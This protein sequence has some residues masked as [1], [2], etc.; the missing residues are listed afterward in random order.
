M[1]KDKSG[2]WSALSELVVRKKKPD[3]QVLSD[4]LP[5][6]EWP[7]LPVVSEKI[8][9]LITGGKPDLYQNPLLYALRRWGNKLP[10]A[11]LKLLFMGKTRQLP[12]F[13]SIPEISEIVVV[14]PEDMEEIEKAAS[15]DKRISIYQTDWKAP[16][17]PAGLF[18]L[19]FFWDYLANQVN[20]EK[21]F[22][23]LGQKLAIGGLVILKEYVGPERYQFTG[24]QLGVANALLALF[25]EN[26]RRDI[27]GILLKEQIPPDLG[28]L[29]ANYPSLAV[30]SSDIIGLVRKNFNIHEEEELGGTVISPLL[31]GIM[32]CFINADAKSRRLLETVW[33]LER[34]LL[35]N[36]LLEND[37]WFASAWNPGRRSQDNPG[38]DGFQDDFLL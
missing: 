1:R 18:H 36:R 6:T 38:A 35:K 28:W 34:E 7:D 3:S 32:H 23:N 24:E 15:Q 30:R 17:F 19:A 31:M 9:Q 37:N 27:A 33:K 5:A 22:N 25:P 20:L 11:G 26:N 29:L 14:D 13:Y 10:A 16:D 8:Q 2:F 21:L 12:W 4:N